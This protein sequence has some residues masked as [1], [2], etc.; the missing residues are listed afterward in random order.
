MFRRALL[1]APRL[2]GRALSVTTHS[3][4]GPLSAQMASPSLVVAGRRSYHEKV[5]DH[6]SRPRNVGSMSKT[7]ADVGTGLVGAPACGDVMKLQIRVDPD[8][9]IISDVKFKTF[10]C[11]SAI[12]SSSYLTELVRG[13]TLEEAGRV[14]NTEIAKELCLPPVKLHC[15]MLAEDAIKSAI[16]N[17]YTKNPKSQSTNLGGTGASIPKI[18]METVIEP[19]QSRAAAV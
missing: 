7:D 4:T 9:N 13:M 18:D 10:G 1:N 17:Y 14:R 5:L 12:A 6:Y 11:G 8:T 15:S 16:S 3:A 2:A 19:G